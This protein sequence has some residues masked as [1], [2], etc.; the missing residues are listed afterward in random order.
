MIRL[1]TVTVA[2]GLLFC[3]CAIAAP[4]TETGAELR[5]N[6]PV[7]EDPGLGEGRGKGAPPD[8]A[9]DW[10]V[11]DLTRPQPVV[12]EPP[13]PSLQSRPGL[14][15]SDAVVLFDSQAEPPNLDAFVGPKGIDAHW[16]GGGQH[17]P[18][19]AG[20]QEYSDPPVVR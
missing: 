11:H 3:A 12:V 6:P 13:T 9:H 2:S 5:S 4:A 10:A 8:A 19:G 7:N 20:D 14:P 15:P 1:T 17:L 16:A 18:R